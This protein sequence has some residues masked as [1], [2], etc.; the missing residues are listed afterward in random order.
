MSSDGRVVEARDFTFL[1]TDVVGS[2]RLWEERPAEMA[3]AM[4]RHDALLA[5]LMTEHN[6]VS[7]KNTGDGFM[8][9]FSI[10]NDAVNAAVAVQ[11]ALCTDV[12]S[13]GIQPKVRIGIHTGSATV[14]DDDFFGRT[15]NR[16]A[17]VEEVAHGGQVI[18]SLAT[19]DLVRQHPDSAVVLA[20][21]GT[22][23]LRDLAE[24]EQLFQATTSAL[25]ED[26]PPLLTLDQFRHNLPIEWSSFVGR[27]EDLRKIENLLDEYRLVTLHGPGGAGKTRLSLQVAAERID[28]YPDGIW[29]TRL[30]TIDSNES[31]VHAVAGAV[32]A[33]ASATQAAADALIDWGRNRDALLL[34]DNCEHVV[35]GVAQLVARLLGECPRL[36]ILATGR[37]GMGLTGEAIHA[38]GPM[39]WPQDTAS[40]AEVASSDAGALFL[41]RAR[42]V[43]P[44]FEIT[45]DNAGVIV[46]ICHRLDG[47]PLAIELA[48]SRLNVLSPDQLHQRLNDRFR[49]LA[50]GDRAAMPRHRTLQATVEWSYDLLHDSERAVFDRLSVFRGGFSMEAAEIVV[51]SDSGDVLDLLGRLVDQS[52]VIVAQDGA[53]SDLRFRMLDTLRDFAHVRLQDRGEVEKYQERHVAFVVDMASTATGALQGPDEGEWLKR[54]DSEFP[55][56]RRAVTWALDESRIDDVLE[57]TGGLKMFFIARD[58]I[59]SEART[60]IEAAVDD[61]AAESG[62]L[63]ANALSTGGILAWSVGDLTEADRLHSRSLQLARDLGRPDDVFRATGD[64]GLIAIDQ[65]D[66]DRA[67]SLF[68]EGLDVARDSDRPGDV[69]VALANLA[70]V[71]PRQEQ[72]GLL[73]EALRIHSDTGRRTG[74]SHVSLMLGWL[75]LCEG[76]LDSARRRFDQALQGF[77]TLGNQTSA[78]EALCGFADAALQAGDRDLAAD[79][80]ARAEGISANI[81]W[82]GAAA[83][84]LT[85]SGLLLQ[86]E[87]PV[88]CLEMLADAGKA[89][90]RSGMEAGLAENLG[91]RALV[92]LKL[93]H[94]DDAIEWC[95]RSAA[96]WRTLRRRAGAAWAATIAAETERLRNGPQA[97]MP[98]Y[99]NALGAYL[100]AEDDPHTIDGFLA[101][102]PGTIAALVAAIERAAN[103]A[104]A[105]GHE[106]E[107]MAAFRAAAHE[108]QRTGIVPGLRDSD[109]E[110]DKW[111]G[112]DSL[113]RAGAFDETVRQVAASFAGLS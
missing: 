51:G 14:R 57:I 49:I 30:D 42:T 110:S 93:G 41:E 105:A 95:E 113:G 109:A 73:Q 111:L 71:V 5:G 37:E 70:R 87:D 60:W 80:V 23:R 28:D 11:L 59:I 52:M 92:G 31:V 98:H 53:G 46:R 86:A 91:L 36:R 99:G 85:R 27:E 101:P 35:D 50:G 13:D 102:G 58:E 6:V 108:R 61:P 10:A 100:D 89:W 33:V 21:L 79:S 103:C 22:H 56:I 55:N 32:G 82:P 68:A 29:L 96:L 43:R 75:D 40:A 106:A 112:P 88:R 34:L 20:D 8:G 48:A 65:G 74:I 25:R 104:L 54:L 7:L 9:V 39:P 16:A 19:A 84:T 62:V 18:V 97:A 3:S 4:E 38:V 17:R 72:E 78:V 83:M 94:N 81:E 77:T 90:S 1:F 76:D 44:G 64:L 107:A 47:I 2:T 69:A 24:P 63:L 15:V 26:F 67:R 45:D 12:W 66:M